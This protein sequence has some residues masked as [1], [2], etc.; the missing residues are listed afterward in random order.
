MTGAVIAAALPCPLLAAHSADDNDDD[1]G[2][3]YGD[4]YTEVNY[5]HNFSGSD[6]NRWDFPHVVISAGLGLGRGWTISAELEYERMHED[7]RWCNDHWDNFATNKLYADKQWS[8]ALAL[9]MGIVDVPLGITNAGGP[10]LTIYDPLSEAALMPMTWHDAGVVLHGGTV[11]GRIDYSLSALV[12]ADLPLDDSRAVGVAATLGWMPAEGLRLGAGGFYGGTEKG[13]LRYC[14]PD[15]VSDTRLA[16][17]VAD[18]CY[19]N[20]GWLISGSFIYCT[21]SDARSV[22]IEAGCDVFSR[23]AGDGG[24]S[25]IPFA[26]YDGVF[27]MPDEDIRKFTVGLNVG[28]SD[29]FVIKAEYGHCNHSGSGIAR[30]LDVSAGYTF[31]F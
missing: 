22:G 14:G 5:G 20:S 13:M 4:V 3:F 26:R 27:S 18:I 8:D 17:G 25:L 6:R 7:G 10:A 23:L 15:F 29:V 28:L 19:D 24:W 12:G 9:K 21:D 2:R 30:T 11:D 16:Y 1:A 31:R